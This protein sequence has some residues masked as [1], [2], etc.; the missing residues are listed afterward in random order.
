MKQIK[1]KVSV[2]GNE[3]SRKFADSERVDWQDTIWEM[4]DV[5]EHSN[6]SMK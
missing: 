3:V 5:I 1:I 4:L 2:D 6:D